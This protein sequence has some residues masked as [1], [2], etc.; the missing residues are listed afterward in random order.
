MYLLFASSCQNDENNASAL[1]YSNDNNWVS[2]PSATKNVDVFYLYPTISSN[3][4][5]IMDITNAIERSLAKGV[6]TAQATLF[7]EHTNVFAP[8]YRQ[9]S[10]ESRSENPITQATECKEF[11]F[12]LADV[13]DAFDYF[14]EH[15]NQGRP[16]IIAGHSQ[17]AMA[18]LELI[19]DRLGK[20][21]E[22]RNKLVAAYL[23]G[24]TVTDKDLE[25]AKLNAAQS[26]DDV[27]AIITFN[28]QSYASSGGPML[29]TGA[30]CIN[31]LSWK[32]DSTK[33]LASENMGAC[34]YNNNTGEF[35]REIDEYCSAQ[36]NTETSALLTSIPAGDANVLDFGPWKDGIYHRFDYAFWYRNLQKNV[37]DRINAYYK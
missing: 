18:G 2:L 28:T 29:L 27:G 22:L 11:I 19:K 14:I 33:A 10:T 20:N 32:T 9:M 23:I 15:L 25:I 36:I 31:P 21:E 24:C 4:S 12:G 16:F 3:E 13:Y 30:H 7:Q 17:G 26:S 1:N 8:Y 34:F 37:S 6:F 5:G 35:Q